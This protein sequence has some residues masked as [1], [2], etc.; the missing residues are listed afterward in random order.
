ML[1]N[2][3]TKC[4]ERENI[5]DFANIN[6]LGQCNVNCYFCLGKDIENLINHRRDTKV[7]FTKWL[8]FN[9]FIEQLKQNGIKKVYITG[10]NTDSLLYDYLGELISYLKENGFGVG[11]RTNGFLAK[12]NI[13]SINMCDLS[14][15]YSI[16]TLKPDVNFKIMKRNT[17]PDWDWILSNTQRSRISMVINRFNYTELYDIINLCK[18]HKNVRYLQVRRISTDTRQDLL[19]EDLKIY[20]KLYSEVSEKYKVVREFHKAPVYNINGIE[21]V[22]WRTVQTSVSSFNYF[23]DGTISCEYFIV[24]GY[25]KN[26]LVNISINKD[27]L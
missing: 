20:E 15:G 8:N 9:I 5:P 24:E 6:L 26:R 12:Q 3:F 14:V 23:T 2:L 22:F 21:C 17:I 1:D 16:H 27:R 13:D 11:L 10:Q 7:H 25:L 4:T 18:E 19:C